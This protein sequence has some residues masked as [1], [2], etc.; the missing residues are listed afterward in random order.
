[1]TLGID[2]LIIFDCRK[3][4]SKVTDFFF[5]IQT[6]RFHNSDHGD[7]LLLS[8]MIGNMNPLVAAQFIDH[9]DDKY[10]NDID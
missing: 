9:M 7:W 2:F 8:Y 10:E 3:T 4:T 6:N 5:P 1:M